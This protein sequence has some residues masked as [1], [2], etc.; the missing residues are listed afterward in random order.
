MK[1]KKLKKFLMKI[2]NFLTKY[3]LL[4]TFI[5]IFVFDMIFVINNENEFA[6]DSNIANLYVRN[7]TTV[8]FS[9]LPS[10][11]T[12]CTLALSLTSEK[13]CGVDAFT[14]RKLRKGFSFNFF[15]M[16]LIDILLFSFYLTC[17]VTDYRICLLAID[18]ISLCYSLWFAIQ[19]IPLLSK[20]KKYTRHVAKKIIQRNNYDF[21]KKSKDSD[22]ERIIQSIYFESGL[23]E[24]YLLL[25]RKENNVNVLNYLLDTNINFL[26]ECIENKDYLMS[27]K[28]LN[29]NNINVLD[30]IKFSFNSIMEI[31]HFNEDFDIIEINKDRDCSYQIFNIIKNLNIICDYSQNKV[32]FEKFVDD[33]LD[34]LVFNQSK[35]ETYDKFKIKIINKIV[36]NSLPN[37]TDFSFLKIINSK[38]FF[39]SNLIG[40]RSYSIYI[41]ILLYY[42]CNINDKQIES[43]AR[44]FIIKKPDENSKSIN[45]FYVNFVNSIDSLTFKDLVKYLKEILDYF[46]FEKELIINANSILYKFSKIIIMNC[47]LE[48]VFFRDFNNFNLENDF[49]E[50]ES[51]KPEDQILLANLLNNAW[52]DITNFKYKLNNSSYLNFY[53][54][55][56]LNNPYSKITSKFKNWKQD[57]IL[58]NLQEKYKNNKDKIIKEKLLIIK[59]ILKSILNEL[60][61]KIGLPKKDFNDKSI[62]AYKAEK[63]II[64]TKD[65]NE[66]KNIIEG[67]TIEKFLKKIQE[68]LTNKTFKPKKFN[69]NEI[70]N[71]KFK[72][73]TNNLESYQKM[74]KI[75]EK[76]KI[77]KI[78]VNGK[79]LFWKEDGIIFN[80]I[81]NES[82]V[83]LEYL[84]DTEINQIID[85]KYTITNGLYKFTDDSS[86]NSIFISR[87][88]LFEKIKINYFKIVFIVEYYLKIDESKIIEVTFDK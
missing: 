60:P 73:T 71:D 16:F 24:T 7:G 81:N 42:L 5:S 62:R 76:V 14:F 33:L 10:I 77:T 39:E 3:L 43:I 11:I 48:L 8:L 70:I 68:I 19:E 2:V 49:K 45:P 66:T 17:A 50:I 80:P 85:N 61:N 88:K 84:N 47:W 55:N 26:N 38:G 75:L 51:L 44:S 82:F 78:Y 74:D 27:S 23:K 56:V 36:F 87:E 21:D 65:L 12:T 29:L 86:S 79:Y 53:E 13:I 41:S 31:F 34:L 20:N 69:S 6:V 22:L 54:L 57:E 59:P 18:I 28:E 52:F 30:A 25:K 35:G 1:S 37:N 46:E 63:L 9:L 58:N 4:F 64:N 15:E 72:Y 83:Y 32:K 40:I 67:L